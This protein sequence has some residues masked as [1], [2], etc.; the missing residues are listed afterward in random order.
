MD[1]ALL[2]PPS[3]A[4]ATGRGLGS[5]TPLGHL[6]LGG[7]VRKA[8]HRAR[9]ID[10]DPERLS[11]QA[12]VARL[13]AAP[14]DIVMLGH[15]ASTPSHPGCARLAAAIKAALPKTTIVYGGVFP[16]FHAVAI[17]QREPAIDIIVR[18]EG[19]AVAAKLLAAIA[20]GRPLD[21]V[22]GIAFR[23]DG[24]VI[25]TPP[26]PLIPDLDAWPAD[27]DLIA[28]WDL[29]RCW[30]RGR[31]A[32]IQFS[33]GCPHLCSYCG[34][35]TF[36]QRWRHR[37]PAA[38]AAEIARLHREH[39]VKFVDFADE[40]P[41]ASKALWREVL[42]RIAALNLPVALFASLRAGDI[43]RDADILPLY[44]KAGFAGVILGIESTD[45][46][47]LAQIAKGSSTAKD[48][49]AIRL[50]RQHNIL[51]MAA[52]IVGF[53]EDSWR[54]YWTALRQLLTY[55]PDLVNAMYATPHAWTAFAAE[56]AGRRVIEPDMVKWDY[57]HQ[58]LETR[59]L[60]PWQ[61]FALVKL[62]DVVLH[63]RPRVL[64]R[65]L[66]HP[67]P[68]VRRDLRWCL[69]RAGRVWFADIA[70]FAARRR[71]PEPLPTL[72]AFHAERFGPAAASETAEPARP[73]A[74]AARPQNRNAPPRRMEL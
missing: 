36:W 23:R 1:V 31:S 46:A 26:A 16:S 60:K 49:E 44:R 13:R 7:A 53:A 33:R 9:L 8:G 69:W 38:V 14:P 72:A 48:R 56:S 24:R 57:R 66:A 71:M 74:R 35:R 28:D 11:D 45:A 12:I 6:L 37:S 15:S 64:R 34:Q 17:L 39:G 47:T 3:P 51:A 20:A 54:S 22:P 29:Y 2:Q 19:E 65:L 32:V 50:L 27:W 61:V 5:Q 68:A 18:G 52:H 41:A 70:E 21:Q 10:A 43:V 42:E 4:P 55:D 73:V 40:N 67:D 25:E 63:L 62:L 59:R 58:V 30:G